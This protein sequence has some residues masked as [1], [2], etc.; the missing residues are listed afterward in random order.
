MRHKKDMTSKQKD[1]L[2][3]RTLKQI[4]QR[5]L[6]V[7]YGFYDYTKSH[8]IIDRAINPSLWL[9]YAKYYAKYSSRE[10][11]WVSATYLCGHSDGQDWAVRVPS[12]QLSIGDALDWLTPAPVRKAKQIGKPVVRQGD[13][14]FVPLSIPAHDMRAIM[15]T[16]HRIKGFD[17]ANTIAH[18][19]KIQHNYHAALQIEHPEHPTVELDPVYIWRAYQQKQLDTGGSRR[20]A[21]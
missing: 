13:M 19:E 1:S 21:D 8:D 3:R 12:T 4:E 15:G 11:W 17:E 2:I 6:S 9:F 10:S 20:G 16:R 14:Y 5:E 18:L 7:P